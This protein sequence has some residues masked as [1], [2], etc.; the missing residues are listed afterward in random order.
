MAHCCLWRPRV[1]RSRAPL[2]LGHD[3]V[4]LR[5]VVIDLR[6]RPLVAAHGC[7]AL[8]G[9][10]SPGGGGS[11]GGGGRRVVPS[12]HGIV[13]WVGRRRSL[14]SR[15]HATAALLGEALVVTVA[16]LLVIRCSVCGA[17]GG[18]HGPGWD[19]AAVEERLLG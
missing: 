1:L 2:L 7:R 17:D 15:V 4:E 14:V 6:E 10:R 11:V 9:R 13:L 5:V 19:G 18:F 16:D 8:R 3:G 12:L